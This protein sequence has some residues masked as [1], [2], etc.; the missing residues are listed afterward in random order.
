MTVAAPIFVVT[1]VH[2]CSGCEKSQHDVRRLFAL[3]GGAFICCECVR[4]AAQFNARSEG[5]L[6]D[7]QITVALDRLFQPGPP[8]MTAADIGLEG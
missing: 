6:T 8:L 5:V 2:N 3:S 1:T 4:L 7:E